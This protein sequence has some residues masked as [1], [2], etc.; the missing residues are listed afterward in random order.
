M[1]RGASSEHNPSVRNHPRPQGGVGLVLLHDR[2]KS[3]WPD[4]WIRSILTRSARQTQ[5]PRTSPFIW[6]DSN[7]WGERVSG[8]VCAPTE[9]SLA[10]NQMSA[11][12]EVKGP[13]GRRCSAS[14]N[15][16]SRTR[17]SAGGEP[18]IQTLEAN[19]QMA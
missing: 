15:D 14:L 17:L 4:I 12:S 1:P 8:C 3:S 5:G 13:Q 2:V 10:A 9:I 18:H 7:S 11:A 6:R 19:I 16:F